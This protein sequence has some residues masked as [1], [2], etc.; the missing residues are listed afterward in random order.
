MGYKILPRAQVE[1]YRVDIVV[2]NGIHKLAIDIVDRSAPG[3]WG[4]EALER[5]QL[6]RQ[7]LLRLGWSV[8]RFWPIQVRD[9]FNWCVSEVR[10]WV[11]HQGA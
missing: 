10:N 9:D 8:M 11:E 3:D 2:V 1:Q 7:R 4:A 5:E 6:K